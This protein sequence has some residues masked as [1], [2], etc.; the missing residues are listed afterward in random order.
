MKDHVFVFARYLSVFYPWHGSSDFSE[1]Y[2]CINYIAKYISVCPLRYP[3]AFDNGK[4]CCDQNFQRIDQ[5]EEIQLRCDSLAIPCPSHCKFEYLKK[6]EK[7]GLFRFNMSINSC[8]TKFQ[9]YR[10]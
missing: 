9:Q 5:T 2:C 4:Q 3:N 6:V 1:D 10:H 8:P 7:N